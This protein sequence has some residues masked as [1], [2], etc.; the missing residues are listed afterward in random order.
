MSK[1]NPPVD[2]ILPVFNQPEWVERCLQSVFQRTQNVDFRVI[3]I[4][5]CSDDPAVADVLSKHA[6]AHPE[7]LI[8]LRN[9]TNRGFVH[10]VNR[11]MRFSDRDVVLLNT[12]TEVSTEWLTHMAQTAYRDN[13]TASVTPLS[14]EASIYSVFATPGERAWVQKEGV[15]EA[16]HVLRQ[17]SR[18]RAP[19]IP[20]GVGFCLY[21]KRNALNIIG[22]F[23]TA[24]GR[25]YGEENDWCMRAKRGGW[26]HVLD[27]GTFVYHEGHVT[28]TACGYLQ[29]GQSTVPEHERILEK[30]YPEL[31]ESINAFLTNDDVLPALRHDLL[32]HLLEKHAQGK[33]RIAFMLHAA[34]HV[35][36]HGGTELHVHDLIEGMR[37]EEDI[38]VLYP[39]Q[40]RLQ[41]VRYV[42][43][44]QATWSLPLHPGNSAETIRAIL[45]RY[46]R[47]IIHVHHTLG[48]GFEALRSARESG[49]RVIYSI[50]DYYAIS[51]NYTLTDKRGYFLGLPKRKERCPGSHETHGAWQDRARE[52]LERVDAIVAPSSS[53]LTLF[54]AVFR[55]VPAQEYII[56]HGLGPELCA[57]AGEEQSEPHVCFLGS[58]H[59]PQKGRSLVE[60]V[61]R[62]LAS[63]GVQCSVIGSTAEE[64]PAI[65]SRHVRFYGRYRRDDLPSILLRIRP[66]MAALLSTYPETF[67]YAL[68]EAWRAGLPAYVARNGALAERV[69]E[70][71]GGW[72]APSMDPQEIAQDMRMRIMG[73]EYRNVLKNVRRTVVSSNEE[74]CA[75]YRHLYDA[76]ADCGK[77]APLQQ[78]NVFA[79]PPLLLH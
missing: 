46:P 40:D 76:L 19:N 7:Q 45:D 61:I 35:D 63:F 43:A 58:A 31:R 50:H 75:A 70:T 27:D 69:L 53:A 4:D 51:P 77:D 73:T 55:D 64:F 13:R 71:G 30:R 36:A 18:Q 1:T 9:E 74:M 38:L 72:V 16:A 47:D 3:A 29:P 2:I 62:S 57:Y 78:Q 54:R 34:P 66:R 5:D 15:E 10:T 48:L 32:R 68:S 24:F 11:G 8:V 26:R 39:E 41:V 22:G 79:A 44:L 59:L 12:D 14:T 56:P 21:I 17:C 42:G 25:G 49:A 65:R 23:D 60:P 37:R 33:R 28:M 52:A 20:T 6:S 67:C